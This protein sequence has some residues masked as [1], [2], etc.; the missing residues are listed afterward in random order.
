MKPREANVYARLKERILRPTDRFE[1]VEN[2]LVTGMPDVN[3]CIAGEEG[4][5]E[6]KAPAEPVRAETALFGSGHP[7]KI[8]QINWLHKQHMAGGIAWLFIATERRLMLIAGGTVAALERRVN[9]L[10]AETL[11][12]KH[13]RWWAEMPVRAP[14]VWFDLRELLARP[15]R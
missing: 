8:E 15:P 7:V 14:E 9:E 11:M 2:G 5:V 12:R 4:W 13:S 1:R 3:Y 6:I 10:S